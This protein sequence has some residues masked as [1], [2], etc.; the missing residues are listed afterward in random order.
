MQYG[1]TNLTYKPHFEEGFEM[2]KL[3]S[4]FKGRGLILNSRLTLFQL[5][6]GVLFKLTYEDLR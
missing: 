3:C 4:I 2:Q 5:R 1:P 6:G